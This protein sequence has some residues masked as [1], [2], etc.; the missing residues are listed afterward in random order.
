MKPGK[1]SLELMRELCGEIREDDGIDPKKIN[2][3]DRS[4]NDEKRDRQLCA[5]ARRCLNLVVPE[6]LLRAGVDRC[7]VVSVDPAPEIARLMVVVGVEADRIAAAVQ[8]LSQQK[9]DLRYEVAG[10]V[11]RKR[12]PDL[13][14]E[15]VAAEEA[16]NG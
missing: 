13:A 1:S 6:M 8:I 14:F 11:H 16:T 7:E 3:R 4:S 10:A 9:G 12:A 15:V 5:Q 2:R